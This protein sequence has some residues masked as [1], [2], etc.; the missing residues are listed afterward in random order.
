MASIENMIEQGNTLVIL[1][2]LIGVYN[3]THY[4]IIVKA[5]AESKA[6]WPKHFF[7][8]QIQVLSL[9]IYFKYDKQNTNVFD[10]CTDK[11]M[12]S[13][14]RVLYRFILNMLCFFFLQIND[15]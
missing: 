2:M 7:L 9:Y 5:M 12:A 11:N 1:F 3:K 14:Q 4:V 10:L 13:S 8:M 6:L 15:C